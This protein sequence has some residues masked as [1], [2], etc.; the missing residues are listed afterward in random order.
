MAIVVG[1]GG[2]DNLNGGASSDLIL[3]GAGA[4]LINGGGGL[5]IILAGAGSDTADGGAGSDLVAVGVGERKLRRQQRRAR[6]YG[7]GKLRR[8]GP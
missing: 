2:S 5:D 8:I 7:G 3:A 1:T 4:D 6:N